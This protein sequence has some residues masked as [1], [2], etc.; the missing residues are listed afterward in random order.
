MHTGLT[1]KN[2][3]LIR[4]RISHQQSYPSNFLMFSGN[5]AINS[6]MLHYCPPVPGGSTLPSSGLCL[7]ALGGQ[8]GGRIDT[9]TG[10]QVSLRHKLI[11]TPL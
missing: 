6:L 1:E 8:Q 5:R 10:L 4:G 11:G 3:G 2:G 9:A 7:Q